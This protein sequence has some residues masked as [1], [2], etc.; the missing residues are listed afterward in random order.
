M[1]NGKESEFLPSTFTPNDPIPFPIKARGNLFLLK[2]TYM[3]ECVVL[4][5]EKCEGG[6]EGGWSGW[7]EGVEVAVFS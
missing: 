1:T 5:R 3:I 7:I 2:K 4:E 6:E